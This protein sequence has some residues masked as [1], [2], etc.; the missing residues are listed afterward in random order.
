MKRKS[1]KS[2]NEYLFTWTASLIVASFLIF[3][4]LNTFLSNDIYS[5]ESLISVIIIVPLSLLSLTGLFTSHHF[6]TNPSLIGRIFSLGILFFPVPIF[7]LICLFFIDS[8][9]KIPLVVLFFSI[10]GAVIHIIRSC[11]MF[12]F[13]TFTPNYESLTSVF[14]N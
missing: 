11:R 2:S 4:M 9:P 13:L 10:F 8:Y 14:R 6:I 7:L 3:V 5:N 12:Y 1:T